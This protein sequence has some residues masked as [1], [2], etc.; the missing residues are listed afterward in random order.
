MPRSLVILL[1]AVA[2]GV[3]AAP[4][5]AVLPGEAGRIVFTSGRDSGDTTARLHQVDF[6]TPLTGPNVSSPFTPIS[7]EQ[8]K[9]ATWSPDRTK[10]AYARGNP[11]SFD[12]EDFEIFVQ[13]LI[14]GVVTPISPD[15][16]QTSDRPAWSPDG[17]KIAYD[18]EVGDNDKSR[19]IMIHDLATGNRVRLTDDVALPATKAAWMPDGS[20]ILFSTG[21]PTGQNTMN[22][23]ERSVD[24]GGPSVDVL[25]NPNVSE[26]Q[27]AISP[28][29]RQLCWS[30]GTGFN[31]S[32]DVYTGP[33]QA[34][35]GNKVNLSDD[36]NKGD[37]NCVW[38]PEGD[39]VA[40]VNGTF[41]KGRIVRAD[42]P[43]NDEELQVTNDANDNRFDGNPDWA[44]DG[45]PECP[46]VTVQT[47]PGTPV[48]IP[49]QCTDTGPEYERTPVR[50]ALTG[51]APA[52]GTATDPL[53]DDSGQSTYTPAPGFVGTDTYTYRGIDAGGFSNGQGT[54]PEGLGDITVNVV[55]PEEPAGPAGGPTGP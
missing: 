44:V 7:I 55:A 8:H 27:H 25:A 49:T 10:V 18:E 42:W 41:E 9:H 11:N 30:E 35:A 16:T 12:K 50:E 37:I 45:R 17:T 39:E 40:Y 28:D 2:L 31:S 4:A 5:A 33:I 14:T 54:G 46:D 52:H 13:D 15:D 3:T 51:G 53:D 1:A 43:D 47:T 6:N 24:K 23:M 34:P 21:D 20:R 32:A 19:D 29:G 48:S 22:V 26:F 38:S 36:P